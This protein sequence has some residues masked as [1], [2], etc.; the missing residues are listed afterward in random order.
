MTPSPKLEIDLEIEATWER[1]AVLRVMII[2]ATLA[3]THDAALSDGVGMVASELLENAV[4]YGAFETLPPTTPR[5]VGLRVTTSD[6]AIEIVVT[7]PVAVVDERLDAFRTT[8]AWLASFASPREAYVARVRELAEG[9]PTG[10]SR[11][12]LVRIAAETP[13][14]L[15]ADVDATRRLRVRAT[16]HRERPR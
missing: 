13:C 14:V 12:G 6:D 1:V 4:R 11:M 3:V 10:G 15:D 5:R 8:L 7:S 2:S 9:P 16:V